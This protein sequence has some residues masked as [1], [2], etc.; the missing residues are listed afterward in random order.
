MKPDAGRAIRPD[1]LYQDEVD[2]VL[3]GA[4]E[5]LKQPLQTDNLDELRA[6]LERL[7]AENEAAAN[8]SSSTGSETN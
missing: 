6:K 3:A 1:G 8:L 7:K 4:K 2:A 5:R